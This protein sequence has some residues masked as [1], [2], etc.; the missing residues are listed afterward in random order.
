MVDGRF[1]LWPCR[2]T[3]I[4]SILQR[5]ARF[6]RDGLMRMAEGSQLPFALARRAFH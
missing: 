2:S 1:E 5:V 4:T 3:A 6:L